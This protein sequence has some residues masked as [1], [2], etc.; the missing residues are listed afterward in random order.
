M[1]DE[2]DRRVRALEAERLRPVPRRPAP[3]PVVDLLALAELV[4]AIGHDDDT[5]EKHGAA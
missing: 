1:S 3:L 4:A 5:D 2:T